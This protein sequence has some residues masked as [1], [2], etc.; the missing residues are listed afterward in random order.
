MTGKDK[1]VFQLPQ[2]L[3]DRL[4]AEARAALPNECCGLITGT[5]EKGKVRAQA[6]HPA[7]NVAEDPA[8]GFLID[9]A[10]HL[11]LS[12]TLRGS[13]REIVGC[14]HSHPGG[15]AVPSARDRAQGGRDG[16]IWLI[17]GAQGS[18]EDTVS[19]KAYEGPDFRPVTLAG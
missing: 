2:K 1:S 5:R 11:S 7:A 12:R 9:P 15:R 17:A 18:A 14:Y 13:G 16:F 19:L 10:V 6:L 8:T 4:A 3:R